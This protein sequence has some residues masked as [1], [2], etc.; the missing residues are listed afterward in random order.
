MWLV[1]AYNAVGRQADA[2]TLCEKLVRHPDT[3]IRRQAKKPALHS[4]SPSAQA[5]GQLDDSNSRFGG[6]RR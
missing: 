6:D 4:E 3:E 2:T 1:S 5:T